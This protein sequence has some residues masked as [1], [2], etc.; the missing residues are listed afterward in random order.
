MKKLKIITICFALILLAACRREDSVDTNQAAKALL[1]GKWQMIN[2]VDEEYEPANVLKYHY[3][4]PGM[5]GDSVIYKSNN[6]MHSFIDILPGE[7]EDIYDYEWIND[8]IIKIDGDRFAIRKLTNTELELY[9]EKQKTNGKEVEI[10][11]FT[12]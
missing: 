12:R 9:Y 11:Y 3:E 4:D 2:L 5:P 10:G 8:S 1:L 7:E 6:K